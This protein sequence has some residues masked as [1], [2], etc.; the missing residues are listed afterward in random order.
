MEAT[1]TTQPESL[2]RAQHDELTKSEK[3]TRSELEKARNL[4][5]EMKKAADQNLR[6]KEAVESKM[7]DITNNKHESISLVSSLRQTIVV[8]RSDNTKLTQES[9]ENYLKYIN[10]QMAKDAEHYT[11]E[12][13][14]LQVQ[15]LQSRLNNSVK[16]EESVKQALL[17]AESEI[18]L[19]NESRKREREQAA[20][21]QSYLEKERDSLS[22]TTQEIR[23]ELRKCKLDLDSAKERAIAS[24]DRCQKLESTSI[25]T[26]KNHNELVELYE[27][28]RKEA[29]DQIT[30][31]S[32]ELATIKEKYDIK[33]SKLEEEN[34]S[35][36]QQLNDSLDRLEVTRTRID[37]LIGKEN[38]SKDDNNSLSTAP[39]INNNLLK[40]VKQYES[41]GK[42]WD[43]IFSDFFEIRENNT[44]LTAI[45]NELTTLNK[46]LVR[47]SE[48]QQQYYNLLDAEVVRLRDEN[49]SQLSF[50][51]DYVKLKKSNSEQMK[52]LTTKLDSLKKENENL[53]ISLNDTSYQL[54]YLLRHVESQYGNLPPEVAESNDL[55]AN[56]H[57]PSSLG[58]DATVFKDISELQQ[59]NQKLMTE[60]RT[61]TTQLNVKSKEA[62]VH[63]ASA[64]ENY[65]HLNETTAKS[66]SLI[67][68]QNEKLQALELRLTKTT[69]E[70][71]LLRKQLPNEDGASSLALVDNDLEEKLKEA[72][73]KY[74][75]VVVETE[76]YKNEMESELYEQRQE[77][78]NIRKEAVNLREE[79]N[80]RVSEITQLKQSNNALTQLVDAR[81]SE[82]DE[83]RN[84]SAIRENQVGDLENRLLTAN[85]EAISLKTNIENI[86]NDKLLISAQLKASEEGYQRLLIENKELSNERSKLSTLIESM[87]EKLGS[88]ASGTAYLVEELKQHNERLS[89]E[90]QNVKDT[91]A[92]KEKELR[93]LQAID[94]QEWKD[95]YQTT[96]GE[97]K[98]LKT[99]YLE[100]EKQ[101][102]AANQERIVAQTKL[103]E[104]LQ[105]VN[106]AIAA[107]DGTNSDATATNENPE[108]TD[109]KLSEQ[110]NQLNE[111]NET[112]L[113]LKKDLFDYKE[114]LSEADAATN[115]ISEEYNKFIIECQSRIEKLSDDLS[116]SNEKV[117]SLQAE[118]EK[119]L[120]EKKEQLEEFLKKEQEWNE[121]KSNLLQENEQLQST[122]KST[123]D[124]V[125]EIRSELDT[126]LRLLQEAEQRYQEEVKAHNQDV[127]IIE[128]LK[129]DVQKLN[130]DLSTSRSEVSV[131]QDRLRTA[132]LSLHKEKEQ[133]ESTYNDMKLRLETSQNEQEKLSGTIQELL[134]KVNELRSSADAVDESTYNNIADDVTQQLR[135]VS[136]T[137]RREKDLWQAKYSDAQQ[138]ATRAESD[139]E[140]V[141]HQLSTTRAILETVRTER[142][143]IIK[144]QKQ[145]ISEARNEATLYKENNTNLRLTVDQ[146]KEKVAQFEKTISEKEAQVEPLTLKV[147]SLE[148]ELKQAKELVDT[149][150]KKQLQWTARS[151][152]LLSKHNK[153][154][155]QEL[156]SLKAELSTVKKG[157]EEK[158][159]ALE[160]SNTEQN[161]LTELLKETKDNLN[162]A[163]LQSNTR[164]K[165]A[166]KFKKDAEEYQKKVE[167]NQ[168]AIEGYQ[169]NIEE[170]KKKVE[171]LEASVK[172]QSEQPTS[173]TNNEDA[174]KKKTDEYN[175]LNAK[176]AKLL[177]KARELMAEKN[178]LSK[179]LETLKQEKTELETQLETLKSDGEKS[180]QQLTVKSEE[181]N[182]LQVEFNRLKAMQS[183]TNNK[184]EK[185]KKEITLLQQQ[186]Q[187]NGLSTQSTENAPSPAT[188]VNT[189]NNVSSPASTDATPSASTSDSPAL[190]RKRENEPE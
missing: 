94:Q 19:Q 3:E 114:R 83:L 87:N 174:V 63:A 17:A 1:E 8:L 76:A 27:K 100:L 84:R 130:M 139:L 159:Q 50:K 59:C 13:L 95:K 69:N 46:R 169:K 155:P 52:Q 92:S 82:I 173:A 140:F 153:T 58:H 67:L 147:Q 150:E 105:K 170:Y 168:K 39:V 179:N 7:E 89:R 135:N 108:F 117:G 123:T 26:K 57:I 160:K 186:L 23:E 165:A 79:I 118:L 75:Q 49:S 96:S 177:A 24:E 190:K 74:N 70:R 152:L 127:E 36:Q 102:A 25:A 125:T 181:A 11:N 15:S 90:L 99:T 88:S 156:E 62:E 188:S 41:T 128:N 6:E 98:Q 86:R 21:Q 111:A 61:L 81:R 9:K 158:S 144:Q 162:K 141:Q 185:L 103:T 180:K 106:N 124:Q 29:E 60:V 176:H 72:E 37:Q 10:I 178:T 110:L 151:A 143:E 120:N 109:A 166:M 71:D 2:L 48:N 85:N 134:S 116:T 80:K 136:A 51:D 131:A 164:G 53:S 101:L 148:H 22:V 145:G 30:Q 175:A 112:I 40:M 44:R 107:N 138:R 113:S 104:A 16:N 55:L 18:K 126:N 161:T 146:L 163:M 20:S 137:L 38:T 73:Q 42:H 121:S 115:K 66:K 157:L 93:G 34:K 149:L 154:D 33:N 35:L 167:E 189:N 32:T 28:Q 122:V 172:T 183:M 78:S 43:D 77:V 54:R 64:K 68:E 133:M 182:N 132:E 47:E 45:N 97:L 187:S 184:N 65:D 5:E 171:E 142:D 12:S 31:L 119:M 91:L 4:L 129:N 14:K 56:A